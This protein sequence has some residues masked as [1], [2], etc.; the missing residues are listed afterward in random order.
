MTS[1]L[2]IRSGVVTVYTTSSGGHTILLAKRKA[3]EFLGELSFLSKGRHQASA[4]VVAGDHVGGATGEG[5]TVS[6]IPVER[7]SRNLISDC[8]LASKFF[9]MIC[10]ELSRAILVPRGSLTS[11]AL[12]GSGEVESV[13][14]RRLSSLTLAVE[15]AAEKPLFS[16][17]SR[18]GTA[19]RAI[20]EMVGV[21]L[22]SEEQVLASFQCRHAITSGDK[23]KKKRAGLLVL[24]AD[25]VSFYAKAFASKTVIAVPVACLV[26]VAL[27]AK[28]GT[29]VRAVEERVQGTIS[30]VFTFSDTNKAQA[31]GAA[32][33]NYLAASSNMS[34]ASR[35]AHKQRSMAAKQRSGGAMGV[36]KSPSSSMLRTFVFSNESWDAI[37]SGCSELKKYSHG[38]VV[39]HEGQ[40]PDCMYQ[41]LTGAVRVHKV[42]CP[43]PPLSL[44]LFQSLLVFS[45]LS[46]VHRSISLVDILS[47]TPWAAPWP[48]AYHCQGPRFIATL[49]D[50]AL[51]G[52]ISFMLQQTASA[53]VVV[54]SQAAVVLCL[55]LEP[56]RKLLNKDPKL[57]ACFFYYLATVLCPRILA[58]NDEATT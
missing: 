49:H 54:H 33:K 26:Q 10:L 6:V 5:A 20:C 53:D 2:Y 34:D 8:A 4:T 3:G 25:F 1:F 28:G 43:S 11:D 57:G 47:P 46:S 35:A 55:K 22:V 12:D 39:L 27:P 29:S 38:D 40:A 13:S 41:L 23:K 31:A 51:F 17:N 32:L 48:H 52:E 37:L 50:G 30:H 56:L 7:L 21:E 42:R 24:M 19:A 9:R 58:M 16:D 36:R 44:P 18:L 45:S 14:R 15:K